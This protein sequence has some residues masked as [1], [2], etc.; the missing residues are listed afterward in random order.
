[1]VTE[2]VFTSFLVSS[3]AVGRVT[4]TNTTAPTRRPA[5]RTWGPLRLSANYC[6]VLDHR[7]AGVSLTLPL[8]GG[9]LHLS[10]TVCLGDEPIR[11]SGWAVRWQRPYRPTPPNVSSEEFL[12]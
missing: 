7:D 6:F 12:L 8:P 4:T 2:R 10:Y 1:M 9:K 11:P 5:P 3:S